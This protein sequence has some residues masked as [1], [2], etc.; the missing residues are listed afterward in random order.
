MMV[1]VSGPFEIFMSHI[2]KPDFQFLSG[3]VLQKTFDFFCF[4]IAVGNLKADVIQIIVTAVKIPVAHGLGH[5]DHNRLCQPGNVHVHTFDFVNNNN[6][7]FLKN[8]VGPPLHKK[9]DLLLL[10]LNTVL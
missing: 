10:V 2:G 4:Q 3:L 8:P 6:S 9:L 7:V 5:V 1:K